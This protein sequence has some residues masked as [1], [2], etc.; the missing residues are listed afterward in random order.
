VRCPACDAPHGVAARYCDQ[1]G[2]RL[3]PVQAAV[4]GGGAAATVSN[5][6]GRANVSVDVARTAE[7]DRTEGTTGD[8][9]SSSPT[10]EVDDRVAAAAR[11]PG[12]STDSSPAPEVRNVTALFADLTDYTR[13]LARHEPG[14]V[15]E[16]VATTLS[17]L[18]ETV[19]RFGGR[20]QPQI[21]DTVFALF[22]SRGDG[23]ATRAALCALEMRD[24]VA[25]L[26]SDGDEPLAIRIALAS[27]NARAINGST[28]SNIADE[29]TNGNAAV[30]ARHVPGAAIAVAAALQMI[31]APGEILADAATVRLANG[32]LAAQERGATWLRGQPAPVR[33][34]AVIGESMHAGSTAR[35]LVGRVAERRA[36][37][38]LLAD[39]RRTRRG[40]VAV[41]V[42][43]AG[44]GKSA[45]IADL[46]TEARAA[47]MRW[48]WTE[49]FSYGAGE[50][51]RLV[52]SIVNGIAADESAEAAP[53][54]R[55]VMFG[56]GA[57]PRMAA[58][59]A[60]IIAALARDASANDWRAEGLLPPSNTAAATAIS[61]AVT[62]F[63]GR[64]VD[65]RGPRVLV[66]DD[67]QW[68]DSSSQRLIDRLIELAA[69]APIVVVVAA[70]PGALPSWSQRD[71]VVRIELGGLGLEETREL[72]GS[73]AGA[74]MGR[75]DAQAIYERTRGNPLFVA[76]MVRALLAD[77]SLTNARG[78][79][80]FT[81]E[82]GPRTLPLTLRSLLAA[83]VEALPEPARE[84]LGV[85]SVV[86]VSFDTD[87]LTALV[88]R[89]PRQTLLDLLVD[90]ALV[91]PGP[92]HGAWRFTH[93]L[94]R[95]TAH[96]A[97]PT[98]RRRTLHARLADRIEAGPRPSVA[99]VA[100]HRAAG[101]DVERAVP[102][103]DRAA[104]DALA[105]GATAEAAE[106]WRAAT[107]L[108]GDFD[109]RAAEYRRLALQA[110][111]ASSSAAVEPAIA[112]SDRASSEHVRAV[113]SADAERGDAIRRPPILFDPPD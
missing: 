60:D 84:I 76:Q 77:G 51:Y 65:A 13:M 38:S 35:R 67:A 10:A 32:R 41:V 57:D 44:A 45:L 48:T 101:G 102:M 15:R 23:D 100:R 96:A 46:A 97:L 12:G 19:A 26:P 28:P 1:C 21:G 3:P 34:H 105:L 14:A 80:E 24:A 81:A 85:A 37:A 110:Q 106:F 74:E 61:D 33:V 63:V 9:V 90:A 11:A 7:A 99:R 31:A 75:P 59:V 16:R 112:P 58:R 86:G 5:G 29:S 30:S 8:R 42:G 108:V 95:E 43:D 47:G 72:A 89:P 50:P 56:G 73:I 22:E 17:V 39:A 109:P 18:D 49:N 40:R 87:T 69:T 78:R 55:R 20:R 62:A 83:R 68:A 82:G 27:E 107:R 94:I 93:P 70:R 52:R 54:A 64:I 88:G 66:V 25:E 36:L 53:L 79:A 4:N 2:T 6:A 103:L 104:R 98:P 92:G 91:E 111:H 113:P 71:D